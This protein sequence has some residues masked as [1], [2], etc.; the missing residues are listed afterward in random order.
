M[1][2]LLKW[3]EVGTR[4]YETGVD[5]GVLYPQK[6]GI[7]PEG[8]AWSGLINVSESPSGGEDNPQ[9]ADNIKYLNLKSTEEFAA[10]IECFS[11]PP[12]WSECNGEAEMTE[13]VMLGQQKRNTFGFCYRT[14][15]GNDTN[16]DSFG[17]KLHLIY[18]CSSAPSERSYGT[19][20]DSP[21]AI[22]FSYEIN[23]TP[24]PCEGFAP[25][26]CITIDSTKVDHDKLLAFEEI[27]YG[28]AADNTDPGNPVSEVKA[29][30]PM[31][32]E[33]KLYFAVS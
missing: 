6:D 28:K 15:I 14:K 7:Y 33:L 26:S 10:T 11:Y 4:Y 22:T 25:V 3:D 19:V 2:K 30:L 24:V 23:T 5:R 31:P 12:E 1:S 20:N 32:D 21:E 27:L 29:R 9:Y 8:F 13:G 16:G 18:G 17:Y